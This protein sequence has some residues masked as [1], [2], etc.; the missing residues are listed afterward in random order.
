MLNLTSIFILKAIESAFINFLSPLNLMDQS[1]P[2]NTMSWKISNSINQL[3]FLEGHLTTG[4][5]SIF[6]G[7]LVGI[8]LDWT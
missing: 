2:I 3:G 1:K 7:V 8:E 4:V 5:Q 6:S